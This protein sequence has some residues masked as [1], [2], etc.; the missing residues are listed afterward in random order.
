M[1]NLNQRIFCEMMIT[2]PP[3]DEQRKIAR[4]VESLFNL[5]DKIEKLVEV[6]LSRTEKMTQAILAKAFRG[7]LV[8][9]EAKFSGS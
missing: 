3:V 4:R 2:V 1:T 8:P 5:A 6:E 9:T 7:E